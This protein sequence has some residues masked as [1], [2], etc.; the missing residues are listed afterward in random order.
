MDGLKML[1]TRRSVRKYEDKEV[2]LEIVKK[3]ITAGKLATNANNLQEFKFIVIREKSNLI[4]LA[5]LTNP[6]GAHLKHCAGGIVVLCVPGKYYLEDGAAATEN[7]LLAL[8]A[9]GVGSVWIAGDK[10]QYAD[11]VVKYVGGSEEK[12]VSLIAYGYPAETPQPN[13]KKIEDV[14]FFERI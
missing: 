2:S 10:K 3:A 12:L 13:K 1:Y 7:I 11:E 6:N 14:M 5:E 8:W 9:Q 4:R